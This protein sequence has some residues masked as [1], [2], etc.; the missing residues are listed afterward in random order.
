MSTILTAPATTV[1]W[2]S[3]ARS[4][5]A[6]LQRWWLAY[7]LWRIEQAAADRL[8]AMSDRELKDIGLIRSGIPGALREAARDHALSR[9]Y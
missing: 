2:P 7:T 3:W 1:G 8:Y 5:A 6:T 9:Y 4:L